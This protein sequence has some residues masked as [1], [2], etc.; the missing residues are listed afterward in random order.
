LIH[1]HPDTVALLL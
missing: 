1:G